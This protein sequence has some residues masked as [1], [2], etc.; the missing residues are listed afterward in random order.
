MQ[1][2]PSLTWQWNK[3][4][5]IKAISE[6]SQEDLLNSEQIY[7]SVAA[8]TPKQ[9]THSIDFN[10]ITAAKHSLQSSEQLTF[11]NQVFFPQGSEETSES[12]ESSSQEPP[13]LADAPTPLPIVRPQ[14][15]VSSSPATSP[16]HQDEETK[17]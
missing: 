9:Q 13:H 4:A 14:I 8:E 15:N 5:V 1:R 10:V 12:V 6:V 7:S 16:K 2:Y 11:R 3:Q 17:A